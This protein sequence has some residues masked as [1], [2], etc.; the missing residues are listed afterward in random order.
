MS[1]EEVLKKVI[2]AGLAKP[3]PLKNGLEQPLS[4]TAKPVKPLSLPITNGLPT[5]SPLYEIWETTTQDIINRKEVPEFP[6]GL[7]SLDEVLWGLHKKETA[8]IGG[9]TSHGKSSFAI[10][11]VRNLIDSGN[12]VIYFS[13]EMSKEQLLEKLFCNFCEVDSLALRH[14]KAKQEFLDKKGLFQEWISK[15]RLLIDDK[16][17]Y[18]FDNIVKVCYIIQPDFVFIDYI[19]MISTKGYKSKVDAIEEYV[20][21]LAELGITNNFGV[22]ILSQINRS[23]VE[24]PTMSKFKWAGVLEEHPATC[25]VL[26]WNKKKGTYTVQIEKQR[27]GEV[28]NVDVKFIPQ[29]SKFRDL[30]DDEKT[31]AEEQST[32]QK[33]T[34]GLF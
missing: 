22:V 12:R 3:E 21:K 30:T 10:N 25:I 20:R 18:D 28:K 34:G 33:R 16:Y 8:V 1:Q 32:T 2:N 4:L 11:I 9:R 27:H 13:L 19:Q 26:N 14:G 17:G 6:T 5:L 29:Y 15:L 7:N 23:G 31:F 24:D